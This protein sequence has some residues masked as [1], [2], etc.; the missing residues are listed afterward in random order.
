MGG[1]Q[2]SG[3]FSLLL[4]VHWGEGGGGGGAKRNCYLTSTEASRPIRDGSGGGGGRQFFY[5]ASNYSN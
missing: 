3:C 2:L 1:G 4:A 5:L